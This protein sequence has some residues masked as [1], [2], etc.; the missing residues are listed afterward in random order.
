[1]CYITALQQERNIFL[2]LCH[3]RDTLLPAP[4]VNSTYM[5]SL[6]IAEKALNCR[7]KVSQLML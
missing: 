4:H 3:F 1:M 5:T 6:D 2:E 7:H